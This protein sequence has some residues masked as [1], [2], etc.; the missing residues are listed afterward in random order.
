MPSISERVSRVL[1]TG[2]TGALGP[3]VVEALQQS[4]YPVRVLAL[5]P[6]EPK[7]FSQAT[8]F[9]LGDINDERA[10]RTAVSGVTAIIHMAA[11]LHINTPLPE[12]ISRYK[13]INIDGTALVARAAI[14]AG[15]Q[16]VV[17]FSTMAVYGHGDGRMLDEN[18]MPHPDSAYAETK[19]C[20]ERIMLETRKPD[21]RPFGT[22]LRLAS[23]YGSR[24][25]GNYRRLLQALA[26]N[27]FIPIGPGTNRRTLVYDKDV[28]SAVL[29]VME[30]PN[31]A[32][33]VFNVTDGE[34][35]SLNDIIL[36]ICEAL[37][38]RPP[39]M[40]LPV[41]PL[42]TT[43]EILDKGARMLGLRS[44]SFRGALDK[45]TEDM[46]VDGHRIQDETGFKPKFDLLSG[47]QEAI[48]E[49]RS[50]GEL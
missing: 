29:A 46:A 11:M 42:R 47:W 7:M 41:A 19:L 2:A 50:R 26:R 30:N 24:V 37:G 44:Y 3:R 27:R 14:E 36:S 5:D 28:A 43:V 20:A 10:V 33:R 13:L 15:V 40:H 45:Y 21:G 1:V 16:R 38:R 4:G 48:E 8:D 39:R 34:I 23:V 6:P 12:Q 17:F 18:T 31:A 32:G 22:V 49:M 9:Q 25:K 35:H